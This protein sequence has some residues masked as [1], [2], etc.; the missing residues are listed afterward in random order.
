ML[1]NTSF[2][3]C[4]TLGA[5]YFC[6]GNAF[7]LLICRGKVYIFFCRT[8][9]IGYTLVSAVSR[10]GSGLNVMQTK[11]S[12][13]ILQLVEL[14]RVSASLQHHDAI[15]GTARQSVVMNYLN[16][17]VVL[18]NSACISWNHVCLTGVMFC[19]LELQYRG[20]CGG[21]NLIII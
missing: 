21:F 11:L 20:F 13:W 19:F 12:V 15:T 14:R 5:F 3:S 10:Q 6:F 9:E 4:K 16:T 2:L 1:M 17:Y 7:T 18:L 8:C